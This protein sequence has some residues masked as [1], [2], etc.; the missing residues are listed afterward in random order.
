MTVQKWL[1]PQVSLS[2]VAVPYSQYLALVYHDLFGY[3]LTLNEISFW[4]IGE[5]D[6]PQLQVQ[7]VGAYFCLV[8]REE[9]VLKRR[10]AHKESIR[11]YEVA[12]KAA[13][14]LSLIPTVE[15][16]AISGSLAMGNSRPK[17]GIELFI[18]SSVGCL[19]ITR[20]LSFVLLK[21]LN[22]SVDKI[23]DNKF[24][25]N[26][27]ISTFVDKGNLSMARHCDIYIAHEIA[28]IK[29]LFDKGG[30]YRKLINNNA[31]VKQF[32]P[33]AYKK[34]LRNSRQYVDYRPAFAKRILGLM[35]RCLFQ[36]LELP[37]KLLPSQESNNEK[38]LSISKIFVLRL[39]QIAK[40][41]KYS[42]QD[43]SD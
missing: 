3:P 17:S 40:S 25:D 30:V 32:F 23:V 18:V 27:E 2:S 9:I 13:K 11:K 26:V 15:M 34:I 29:V 21:L 12:K 22:F 35:F 6:F 31:W 28:Q 10:I 37:F 16:V 39:E 1:V 20:V 38:S 41:V 14:L 19:W 8:A 7:R 42:T 5:E 43:S 33:N 4:Q 36:V 24:K